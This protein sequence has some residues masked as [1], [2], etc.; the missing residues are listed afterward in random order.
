[1]SKYAAGLFLGLWLATL[2]DMYR[3]YE[4]IAETAADLEFEKLEPDLCVDELTNRLYRDQMDYVQDDVYWECV[5]AL[6]ECKDF[7]STADTI[8]YLEDAL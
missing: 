2:G 7:P 4:V 6:G 1:M 3:L 8:M 5:H